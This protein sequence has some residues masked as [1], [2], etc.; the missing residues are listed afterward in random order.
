[1]TLREDRVRLP[2]GHELD[3]YHVLEYPDWSCIVALTEDDQAILVEQ[4]RYGIDRISLEFPAGALDEEENPL[5]AARREL[6]EETGYEASDWKSL[7]KMAVEPGRH[8]NYGHVFVAKG[9]RKVAEPTLD[10]TEDLCVRVVR[11]CDLIGL[12]DEG[13]IIH[14]IHVAAVFWALQHRHISGVVPPE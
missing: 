8:T 1:M 11:A 7:G 9:A 10:A 4:Y 5:D 12:V 13:R 14:G 2:D 3:E 6:L